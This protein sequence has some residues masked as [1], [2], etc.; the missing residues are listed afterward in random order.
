M[1]TDVA[2]DRNGTVYVADFGNNRVVS[3]R[4]A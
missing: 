2:V 4:P 3:L 1:T